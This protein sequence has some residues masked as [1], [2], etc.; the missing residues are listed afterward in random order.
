MES[1]YAWTDSAVVLGWLKTSPSHVKVYASHR[2]KNI[3]RKIPV[4]QWR[5][6][7][8]SHNPADLASRGIAP[9]GLVD[10]NLWWSGPPWLSL[11]PGEWPRRLDILLPEMKPAICVTAPVPEEYGMRFPSFSRMCRVTAWILIFLHRTQTKKKESVTVFQAAE[12]LNCARTVLLKV[13]QY[14][15]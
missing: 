8:T 7:D 9:K 2:V 4:H 11:P 6:V 14:I 12:E 10:S 13:S 15:T 3:L 1:V 5:Y